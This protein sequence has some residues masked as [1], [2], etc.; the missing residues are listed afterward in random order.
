MLCRVCKSEVQGAREGQRCAE[1]GG[2]LIDGHA[3][4]QHPRD[5]LLGQT[6]GDEFGIVSIIGRGGFGTVYRAVQFP[7][8]RPIALKVLHSQFYE[9]EGVRQ[10]F[11]QEARALAALRSPSVVTLIRYG[12]QAPGVPLAGSPGFLFIAQE[13]V[14]GRTLRDLIDEE[15]PLPVDRA[16][17]IAYQVLRGLAEAHRAGIVH[18]D[19]KPANIM[20]TRE[21]LG[22]E[23]AKV[24]DFGIAKMLADD[25]L[26]EGSPTTRSGLAMGTPDYMAP[27]Q[28]DSKLVDHRADIYSLGI[29][30]FEMLAGRKP[31]VA[32]THYMLIT[33]HRIEPTPPLEGVDDAPDGLE[34]LIHRALEKTPD[35][36]FQSAREMAE[37]LR[38]L[39]LA[40]SLGTSGVFPV[41]GGST[42]P[43][44]K[45]PVPQTPAP[46]VDMPVMDVDST[47]GRARPLGLYIG[48]AL[49]ALAALAVALWLSGPTPGTVPPD[50]PPPTLDA[51]VRSLAP[52]TPVDAAIPGDAARPQAPD[53]GASPGLAPP[54]RP[55]RPK[56]KPKPPSTR[57]PAPKPSPPRQAPAKPIRPPVPEGPSVPRL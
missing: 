52:S 25:A 28:T 34:E 53:Q 48:L 33:A 50:T 12:E 36:R 20:V 2:L 5:L 21:E 3:L 7:L 22:D 32:D 54:K 16:C 9:N 45:T 35:A 27:E 14:D 10:R 49:T 55:A 51:A 44:P 46:S 56:A 26:P 39:V 24:L 19:L 18:R 37:G 8:L 41:P 6:I 17:A 1:C 31:Y 57:K 29:I 30:L 47:D 4:E 13:F 40:V 38:E 15:A 23:T 11:L 42:K 43:A